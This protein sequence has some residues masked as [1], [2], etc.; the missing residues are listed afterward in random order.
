MKQ[1]AGSVQR[2]FDMFH[3]NFKK[4]IPKDD[5]AVLLRDYENLKPEIDKILDLK[6]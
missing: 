3:R 4:F 2:A 6:L 1:T 5:G